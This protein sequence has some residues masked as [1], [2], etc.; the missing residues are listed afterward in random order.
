[1]RATG[2]GDK[3]RRSG[4]RDRGSGISGSGTGRS[5]AAEDSRSTPGMA[6]AL[7]WRWIAFRPGREAERRHG[8]VP[9]CL[10]AFSNPPIF[11]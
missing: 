5:R 8:E 9:P 3:R 11:C 4:V 2:R 6:I 10:M 7:Y 1:M